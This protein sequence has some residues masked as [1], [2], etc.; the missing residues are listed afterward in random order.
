MEWL[1]LAKIEI[2]G[3]HTLAPKII[4]IRVCKFC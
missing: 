4:R 3:Y 2:N 1:R